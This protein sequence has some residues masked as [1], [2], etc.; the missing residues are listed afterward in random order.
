MEGRIAKI[1]EAITGVGPQGFR[2]MEQRMGRMEERRRTL[3]YNYSQYSE[4]ASEI[5]SMSL[6][7]K[8]ITSMGK[9]LKTGVAIAKDSSDIAWEAALSRQGLGTKRIVEI[10]DLKSKI[11]TDLMIEAGRADSGK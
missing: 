3:K 11:E 5:E 2:A 6:P 9:L 1:L 7:E 8:A 4:A 10:T